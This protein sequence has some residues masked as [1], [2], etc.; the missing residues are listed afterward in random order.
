MK[1]YI[2]EW[3][4]T[5]ERIPGKAS[6]GRT[7][8]DAYTALTLPLAVGQWCAKCYVNAEIVGV[9]LVESKGTAKR[10]GGHQ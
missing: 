2:I 4:Q 7:F 8:E 3:R 6:E 9:Q 5:S 1:R 10:E